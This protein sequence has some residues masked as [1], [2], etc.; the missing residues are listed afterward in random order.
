MIRPENL[1]NN[2][3]KIKPVVPQKIKHSL[4]HLHP[5]LLQVLYN[6]GL[7]EKNHIQAFIEGQYL[8]S[9]DP[10][11]LPDMEKAIARIGQA[12][13]RDE[14]IIVYGD[15]DAD[16]VTST[17]L[18]TEALRGLGIDRQQAQPYIPDR[19]DEGY[20]LNEDALTYLKEEKNAGLVIS[21]DCGI[22][23]IREVEHANQLGLDMIISDHHSLGSRMPPALAVINPKRT[24]SSYPEE[25]LA[26]VG[27]AYKI[28]Q[29]LRQSFPE[30]AQFDE[31]NLL[32]LV[33]LGTVADL[34]PL[35]GEN[36]KLVMD[37]L[38]VLNTCQRPGLDALARVSGLKPGSMSAESIAFALG[39]RINAAGRLSH[40]YDAAKLLALNNFLMAHEQ[41]KKL[42]ALNRE[43]QRITT[44][45]TKEAE[46]RIDPDAPLIFAAD[47]AFLPG[48]VG[49]VASR[50]TEKYYRPSII[51][52]QGEA[53][54]RG[55]CR[56][57][58]EFHITD[59]LD[60]VQDLLVRHG[61]HAQ[62]AGFTIYNENLPEF[63]RRITEIAAAEL[64]DKELSPTLVIDAEVNLIDVDWALQNVLE[65]LEPT[66][67]ANDRPV[68]MS[69]DVSVY[70]HRAVGQDGAH[71]QLE[72]GDGDGRIKLRC[73]AFR[74]GAWAGGLPDKIDLA[75]MLGVNEWN[76]RRT[77]Q[78]LVKDIR[79]T[80]PSPE[81]S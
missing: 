74:Q 54:S 36:R 4:S 23:S 68:F 69:R 40:A 41:A 7:K 25:M 39:P 75:Y 6:R 19:I 18:L 65:D 73:I 79:A 43:R 17:V 44:Q 33:A 81:T 80:Q 47:P 24:D 63:E 5:V 27:I 71:L 28:A 30:Q 15:F 58:P 11:L 21:V 3:W 72:V 13:E 55:S 31:T 52:E 34:A 20:G 60:Q 37:G 51:V 10:F 77:L 48:I 16:G 22:R 38:K 46:E 53:E 56:S 32:D 12:I 35:Q 57:I 14:T 9:T 50:L 8:E 59:A 66:G 61:G 76:G 78:L 70:N 49:L 26:G 62:A 45:L 1:R 64:A 2:H 29:A 42:N 67:E